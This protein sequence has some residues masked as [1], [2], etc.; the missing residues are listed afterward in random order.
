MTWIT[1]YITGKSDFRETVRKKLDHSELNTMP[2][3]VENLIDN[4]YKHDLYWIDDTTELRLIKEAI[5]GKII[6][7]YRLRFF[8]S[9]EEFIAYQEDLLSRSDSHEENLP[10]PLNLN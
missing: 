10:L 3:Y 9:L 6:W 1:L 8:T 2:G 4:D 5:G 7:K